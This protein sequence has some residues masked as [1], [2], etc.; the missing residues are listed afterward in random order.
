MYTD[1]PFDRWESVRA[2][3]EG[4]RSDGASPPALPEQCDADAIQPALPDPFVD[5]LGIEY[6]IWNGARLVPAWPD[7]VERIRAG[8]LASVRRARQQREAERAER[9]RL[10]L[11]PISRLTHVVGRVWATRVPRDRPPVTVQAPAEPQAP[12]S[13]VR[14][15]P[16]SDR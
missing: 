15:D 8:E 16:E 13:S 1:D 12:L 9:R 11:R 5:N 2:P 10:W 4:E 7:E 6:W 3:R 14:A